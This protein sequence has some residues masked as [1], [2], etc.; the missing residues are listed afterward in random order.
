MSQR[1]YQ[2]TVSA[3]RYQYVS[4]AD[5]LVYSYTLKNEK[6]ILFAHPHWLIGVVWDDVEA[7]FWFIIVH[8]IGN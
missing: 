2:R 8:I 7:L 6:Y 5:W 4:A 1:T 3:E